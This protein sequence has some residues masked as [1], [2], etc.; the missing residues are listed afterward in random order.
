MLETICDIMVEGYKRNWITSRDGNSSLRTHGQ[1]HFYITPAGVRKQT[2]Q[3]DQ[4]KKLAIYKYTD[5]LD[6]VKYR[7]TTMDYTSISS[8]LRPSGELPLH[9]GLQQELGNPPVETRVVLHFHPTYCVAAIR[10]GIKLDKMAQCFPELTQYTRVAPNVGYIEP[11]TEELGIACHQSMGLDAE[12]NLEY[13]I[14]GFEGHG[15]VAV[16]TTPWRAFEHIERLSHI[17]EIVLL[18][19]NYKD[20]L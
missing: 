11:K 1:S 4:F 10:A 14:V 13:D 20:F 7:S 6:R 2:L 12:G 19:G 9:L 3:P 15:V 18:S 16:A 8:Q 17:C 5:S